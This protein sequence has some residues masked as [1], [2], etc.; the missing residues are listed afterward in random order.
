M[1]GIALFSR[2]LALRAI[3]GLGQT[4]DYAAGHTSKSLALAEQLRTALYQARYSS[5][6]MSLGLIGKRPADVEKAK[7]TFQDSVEQIQQIA[8]ELRPLLATE[9]ELRTLKDLEAQLPGWQSVRQAMFGLADAGDFDSLT[10]VQSGEAHAVVEAVDK[11][12][13]ALI[14]LEAKAMAQA[15]VDSHAAASRV[16]IVQ[17]VFLG[18]AAMAG[19]IVIVIIF[20][21]GWDAA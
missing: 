1:L 7:Q 20:R 4:V 16:F 13:V 10:K 8:N 12:A 14:G 15:S 5:R 21:S 3:S 11:C 17:T 9:D 6:G 2:F 18:V 19:G